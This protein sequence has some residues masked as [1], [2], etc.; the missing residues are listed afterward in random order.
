VF[1]V[2][3]LTTIVLPIMSGA[4]QFGIGRWEWIFIADYLVLA[5]G[6]AGS[7]AVRYISIVSAARLVGVL[8]S[9]AYI[10]ARICCIVLC[11][12]AIVK[13]RNSQHED[14]TITWSELRA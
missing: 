11:G 3:Y 8:T 1:A 7:I 9:P 4:N 6:I 5:T 10:V 12:I 13:R 14:L 2:I